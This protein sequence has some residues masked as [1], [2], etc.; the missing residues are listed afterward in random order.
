MTEGLLGHI[1]FFSNQ[2]DKLLRYLVSWR[3]QAYETTRDKTDGVLL[4][5]MSLLRFAPRL[6]SGYARVQKAGAAIAVRGK[7]TRSKS[8]AHASGYGDTGN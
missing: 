3:S 6:L 4:S 7:L 8:G 1:D 2:V 5:P